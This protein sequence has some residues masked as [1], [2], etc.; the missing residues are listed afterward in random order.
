MDSIFS[1][2][3]HLASTRL[4]LS[5]IIISKHFSRHGITSSAS[6]IVVHHSACRA[7]TAAQHE[8]KL[9]KSVYGTQANRCALAFVPTHAVLMCSKS[10][11][12]S[13]S[14]ATLQ[15]SLEVRNTLAVK[16]FAAAKSL[17]CSLMARELSNLP[18][19]RV[20]VFGSHDYLANL[21]GNRAH[22]R[23]PDDIDPSKRLLITHRICD[24]H[25]IGSAVSRPLREIPMDAKDASNVCSTI[26]RGTSLCSLRRRIS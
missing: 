15:S 19:A 16:D 26:T 3:H 8:C 12:T 21:A 13:G 7:S 10:R 17:K 11:D 25:V 24:V 20:Y 23:V 9:L 1:T 14:T 18:V 2:R 4:G 5:L 6:L 22:D